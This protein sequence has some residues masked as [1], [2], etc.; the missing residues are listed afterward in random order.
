ML[1]CSSPPPPKKKPIFEF[2]IIIPLIR[3][4]WGSV[5]VWGGWLGVSSRDLMGTWSSPR[6]VPEKTAKSLSRWQG[7]SSENPGGEALEK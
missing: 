3:L 5:C 2:Y 7:D 1:L 4:Y 6:T